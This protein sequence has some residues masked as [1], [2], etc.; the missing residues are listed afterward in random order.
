MAHK[1]QEFIGQSIYTVPDVAKLTKVP[2]PNIYNWL[3]GDSLSNKEKGN[4]KRH[5]TLAHQLTG[6]TH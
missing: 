4:P 3:Y 6:G 2:S 5:P 1:N